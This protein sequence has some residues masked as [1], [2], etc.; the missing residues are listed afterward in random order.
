MLT[1]WIIGVGL[2]ASVLAQP[3]APAGA[4]APATTQPPTTPPTPAEPPAPAAAKPDPYVLGFTLKDIDGKDHDLSKH[5]GK[6][7]L[8]VNVASQCGLTKPQYKG[9]QDLYTE[10]KDKGLVILGFPANNFRE[11]EPGSDQEIKA[12]CEKNFG[13]T[14]PLF[15]KISVKGKDQH[16]LFA[17]LASQ[18][19]PI[20]GDPNWNFT[21]FLVD[22]EGK[23]VARFEPQADPMSKEIRGR[24]EELLPPPPA[25]VK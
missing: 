17:R 3:G 8:I 12:Y 19:K 20:G 23:V 15:A 10:Y 18:P 22:R 24:I 11:Q 1:G 2:I 21:K 7:V 6:V 13:V 14:F 16:P 25:G 9:L 4:P 5:K